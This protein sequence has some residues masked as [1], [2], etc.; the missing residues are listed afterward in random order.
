MRGSA[1]SLK[2]E[3]DLLEIAIANLIDHSETVIKALGSTGSISLVLWANPH[4]FN[5]PYA[6]AITTGG[7][8][9]ADGQFEAIASFIESNPGNTSI[10]VQDSY[11]NLDLKPL[12]FEV[13]FSTP[14]SVRQPDPIESPRPGGL[15]I[16]R[17]ETPEALDEF[18]RAAALGFGSID[19]ET[20][21]APGLLEDEHERFYFG[22]IGGEII[23]GVNSF[24]HGG[25][26]GIYTLFT[27]PAFRRNGFAE[28]LVAAALSASPELPA[29]TNPGDMSDALF[30]RLG[31]R[32]VGTRTIWDLK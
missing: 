30:S 15:V 17:V 5:I 21:F 29:T 12:G 16:T 3:N 28:S 10:G 26:V 20:V 14:W 18:D 2:M 1:G 9:R 13:F 4:R 31:F 23:T 8:D 25:V 27:L 22:R 7:A 11:S 19:F 32:H 6:N 24:T